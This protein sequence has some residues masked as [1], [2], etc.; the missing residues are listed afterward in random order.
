[1]FGAVPYPGPLA[2][3]TE[4]Y[5]ADGF[6]QDSESHPLIQTEWVSILNPNSEKTD[7]TVVV[8]TSSG[9]VEHRTDVAAESVKLIRMEKLDIVP[10]GERYGV[11]IKSV[12]PVVVHQT[13]RSLVKGGTPSSK[14]TFATMAAVI[15]R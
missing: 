11:G 5:Y 10:L 12:L 4:W 8:Y 3:E 15:K 14:S 6:I 2:N 7:I 9:T 1:M 13:R